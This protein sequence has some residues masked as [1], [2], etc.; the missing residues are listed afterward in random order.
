M[1]LRISACGQLV[2]V[3]EGIVLK[4]NAAH[5]VIPLD[6]S[7]WTPGDAEANINLRTEGAKLKI[8]SQRALNVRVLF[9]ASVEAHLFAHQAGTDANR[10]FL[11]LVLVHGV[12]SSCSWPAISCSF[13]ARLSCLILYSSCRAVR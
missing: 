6:Q 1:G 10:D 4:I 5:L 12:I 13:S 3:V 9:V 7:D 2:R 8:L 11:M